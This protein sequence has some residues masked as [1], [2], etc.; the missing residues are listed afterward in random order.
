MARQPS[1][2]F[3]EKL[4]RKVFH[5]QNTAAQKNIIGIEQCNFDRDRDRRIFHKFNDA[6][7][8]AVFGKDLADIAVRE[9]FFNKLC[10]ISAAA[11][12][13]HTAD[14]TAAADV[15]DAIQRNVAQLRGNT[16][17][18][19]MDPAVAYALRAPKQISKWLYAK[20]GQSDTRRAW[21]N[22]N[23][24][25]NTYDDAGNVLS[26]YQ[27]EKFAFSNV[28]TWEGDYIWMRVEEM[29]FNAAEAACRLGDEAAA[30]KYLMAVMS[31]RDPSY[32]CNKTGTA[33]GKLTTDETGS[34]LEEIIIQKRIE[35][36]GEFGR[37]FDI[38]RLKQGFQRTAAQGWP[39]GL[40]LP[41]RPTANPE[42][43]MWV[44]T[45]PQAEFD[46]NT[47]M[48]ISKDQNPAGDE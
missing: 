9:F 25:L 2:F 34:L 45:I 42:N 15:F 23:H 3:L 39:S 29:Y 17:G 26:G 5:C 4:H 46:G 13:F 24:E 1:D 7:I 19:H 11:P 48:D 37:T 27:Q 31:Q 43:Y 10:Q 33:M 35:L 40:L 18:A 22:P 38:R 16:V 30:K 14:S 6:G 32:T 21:W 44:V 41:K 36:W 12:C 47:N 28:A 8:V 20:M